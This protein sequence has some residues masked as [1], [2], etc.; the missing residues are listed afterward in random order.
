MGIQLPAEL[1]TNLEEVAHHGYQS[2]QA[3][4]PEPVR[5]ALTVAAVLWARFFPTHLYF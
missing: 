3:V 4:E 2:P 1:L 5:L